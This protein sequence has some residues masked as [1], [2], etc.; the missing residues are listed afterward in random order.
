MASFWK[1]GDI[2]INV[3]RFQGSSVAYYSGVRFR[4]D[5][6]C[7]MIDYT[8]ITPS[9]PGPVVAEPQQ[10]EKRP[11]VSGVHLREWAK[12][13]RA[14]YP[15]GSEELAAKS[16][17]GMFPGKSVPRAKLR[18]ALGEVGTLPKGRPIGKT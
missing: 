6:I 5:D 4:P 2:E 1:S 7:K 10:I 13:F 8:P 18:E 11:P 12:L 9:A 3:S 16:A 14:A 15:S 17:N